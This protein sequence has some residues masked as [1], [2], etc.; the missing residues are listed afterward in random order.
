MW[1]SSLET[2]SV[3]WGPWEHASGH[4]MKMGQES[5]GGGGKKLL[6]AGDHAGSVSHRAGQKMGC[7]GRG[8]RA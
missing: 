3:S 6:E 1:N 8:L 7:R 5:Q 4:P 2:L